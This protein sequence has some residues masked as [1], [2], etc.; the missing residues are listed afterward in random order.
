MQSQTKKGIKVWVFGQVQGVGFR[1]STQIQAMA[2]QVKGYARNLDDGSVEILMYGE[3]EQ[4]E[5]LL[6]WVKNGGPAHA[7][8]DRIL[9]EPYGRASVPHRFTIG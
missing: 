8:V 4:V 7:R 6:Q 5:K 9:T 1:Y 2:L 3:S